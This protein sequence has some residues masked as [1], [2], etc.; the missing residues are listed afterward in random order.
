MKHLKP[1]EMMTAADWNKVQDHALRIPERLRNSP[2]N[3]PQNT[4][5]ITV[6]NLTGENLG[7]FS[8]VAVSDAIFPDREPQTVLEQ[9]FKSGV[10]VAVSLPKGEEGELLCIVQDPIPS[11]EIGQAMI[12]GATACH[13]RISDATH[14]Y[15]RSVAGYPYVESCS[16]PTS[17]TI[18]WTPTARENETYGYVLLSSSQFSVQYGVLR[19]GMDHFEEIGKSTYVVDLQ[20]DDG[21]T[22]EVEVKPSGMVESAP[23]FAWNLPAGTPVKVENGKIVETFLPELSGYVTIQGAVE[24]REYTVDLGESGKFNGSTALQAFPSPNIPQ[25]VEFEGKT[26]VI[27]RWNHAAGKWFFLFLEPAAGEEVIGLTV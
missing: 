19:E 23:G 14:R 12:L 20:A 25:E 10:E 26:P 7:A 16:E 22:R 13:I 15:A 27:V 3:S 11:G 8:V 21:G 4:H 2:R 24:N 6:E 17:I 5:L 1:G 9:S 18:L